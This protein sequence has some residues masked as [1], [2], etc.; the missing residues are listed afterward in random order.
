VPAGPSLLDTNDKPLLSADPKPVLEKAVT[1]V[2][3]PFRGAAGGQVA[4]TGLI[5]EMIE[6]LRLR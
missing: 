2:T 4:A 3:G 1:T 6:G 5:D